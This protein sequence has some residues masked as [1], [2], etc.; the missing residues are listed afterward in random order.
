MKGTTEVPI[1]FEFFKIGQDLIPPPASGSEVAPLVV[2]AGLCAISGHAVDI[3]TT[4]DTE[5]LQKWRRN[6]GP[7]IPRIGACLGGESRPKKPRVAIGDG[8]RIPDVR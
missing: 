1:V 6:A 2:V 7:S 3:G 5:T 4:T 8:I